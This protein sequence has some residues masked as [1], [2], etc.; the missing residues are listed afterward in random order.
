MCVVLALYDDPSGK[1]LASFMCMLLGLL[2]LFTF[3]QE[4][5]IF[6][7]TLALL[8]YPLLLLTRR[9]CQGR[10]GVAVGFVT[11]VY[12]LTWYS[13]NV[14]VFITLMCLCYW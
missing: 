13:I 5:L 8:V 1:H 10:S 4:N 6:I 7:I 9:M 2:A 14:Y 11:L 3:Y 12:L